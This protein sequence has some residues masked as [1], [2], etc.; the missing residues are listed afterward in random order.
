MPKKV[1]NLSPS[2]PYRIITGEFHLFSKTIKGVHSGSQPDGDTI[3]FKPDRGKKAFKDV[4][5]VPVPGGANPLEKQK[6]RRVEFNSADHCNLRFEAIDSLELH[7]QGTQQHD[8][9]AR[10]ARTEM[11][12]RVGFNTVTFAPKKFIEVSTALPHPIRGYVI[13]RGVDPYGRPVSFVFTG[14]PPKPDNSKIFLKTNQVRQS[15]NAAVLRAGHA[16]TTFYAGLPTDLR[17]AMAG[18]AHF[19]RSPAKGV[20]VGFN[21]KAL[22][23]AGSLAALAAGRIWPK[24]FRRLVGYFKNTNGKPLSGFDSWLRGRDDDDMIWIIPQSHQGNLHDV[25]EISGSK[26]RLK[27]ETEELIIVPR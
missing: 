3:K 25:Y 16:Y 18:E 1:K 13:T 11:L 14:N 6:L 10:A 5:E 17:N 15:V 19:P 24:L 21:P 4:E 2:A 8:T 26:I 12:D 20:W 23:Q 7:F 22:S 9:L 27:F